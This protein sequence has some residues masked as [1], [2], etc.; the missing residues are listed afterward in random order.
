MATATSKPLL[1][2]DSKL[3]LGFV[4]GLA[5]PNSKVSQFY[6]DS[7]QYFDIE[8]IGG[9]GNYVTDKAASIGYSIG[10][11]GRLALA[12]NLDFVPAIGLTRFNEGDYN[13]TL[14][15]GDAN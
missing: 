4:A 5:V 6:S 3:H 7:K 1:C 14:P 13:L 2:S 9:I 11:K 15:V 12:A 10:I 8:N